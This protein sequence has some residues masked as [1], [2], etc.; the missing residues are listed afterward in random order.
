MKRLLDQLVNLV[1]VLG[2]THQGRPAEWSTT[3]REH[4]SNVPL[5]ETRNREG[6]LES[7]IKGLLPEIVPILERHSTCL[8][9]FHDRLHVR[10]HALTR[11]PHVQL[12]IRLAQLVRLLLRQTRWIITVQWIMRRRLIRYNVRSHAS[13]D[14][15]RLDISRVSEQ[16]NAL[17]RLFPLC[18]LDHIQCFLKI[19]CPRLDI[20]MLQPPVY[21]CLANFDRESNPIVHRDS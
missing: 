19:I 10:H 12:R 13:T 20:S 2:I 9:H 3:L 18:C 21:G 16:G 17:R 7:S 15:F 4:R 14:K 8:R 11:L 6:F 1:N 5:D